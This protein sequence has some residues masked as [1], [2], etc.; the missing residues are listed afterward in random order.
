MSKRKHIVLGSALAGVCSLR[1][2]GGVESTSHA[3]E[4]VT[5]R[6]FLDAVEAAT[7]GVDP[8]GRLPGIWGRLPGVIVKSAGV[9]VGVSTSVG[10]T[11]QIIICTAP[12]VKQ[13]TMTV[14]ARR[15]RQVLTT[16]ELYAR[17]EHDHFNAERPY[18][19]TI[20]LR[21][22][23]CD[24]W[25]HVANLP[26]AGIGAAIEGMRYITSAADLGDKPMYDRARDHYDRM[27]VMAESLLFRADAL[28][29]TFPCEV[30]V[31]N[32]SGQEERV[33]LKQ[34]IRRTPMDLRAMLRES[35]AMCADL[36]KNT[37]HE[38]AVIHD[39][40]TAD[41]PVPR[42]FT[43]YSLFTFLVEHGP[44]VR[45]LAGYRAPPDVT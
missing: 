24:F 34:L 19:A 13:M 38:L 27:R 37:L 2:M 7:G 23:T 39:D 28:L 14:T 5:V 43:M 35:C 17:F 40:D 22:G 26:P 42:T 18:N 12:H 33:D 15:E 32:P 16:V 4:T 1:A 8:L 21:P 9:T 30:V 25:E 41:P 45:I 20:D 36:G 3:A 44:V 29:D 31:V 6:E 10:I 11:L